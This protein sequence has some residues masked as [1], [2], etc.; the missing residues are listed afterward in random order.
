MK[1]KTSVSD[2][3]KF[4]RNIYKGELLFTNIETSK[5]TGGREELTY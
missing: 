3:G 2:G 1:G 5:E 4:R